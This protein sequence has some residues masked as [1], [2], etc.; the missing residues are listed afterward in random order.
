MIEYEK[1]QKS[2]YFIRSIFFGFLVIACLIY[3]RGIKGA[4]ASFEVIIWLGIL[5]YLLGYTYTTVNF[6]LVAIYGIGTLVFIATNFTE[7][8]CRKFLKITNPSF[9][10]GVYDVP[11]TNENDWTE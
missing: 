3:Y 7:R 8:L 9:L 4:L 10:E 11:G 6:T 5:W 1:I 2:K